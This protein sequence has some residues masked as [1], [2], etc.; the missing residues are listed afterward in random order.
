MDA[1]LKTGKRRSYNVTAVVYKALQK[2][3]MPTGDWGSGFM[4]AGALQANREWS[5]DV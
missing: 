1:F 2:S 3:G 4:Q 5:N